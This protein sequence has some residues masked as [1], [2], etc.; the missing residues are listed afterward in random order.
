[1][2]PLILHD[3][4]ARAAGA[5][6]DALE[7][8]QTII[9]PTDTIYGMGGNPWDDGVVGRIRVLKG[10]SPDQPFTLHLATVEEV[11]RFAEI[12]GSA[13]AAIRHLLPGPYTVILPALPAAPACSVSP[14]GVGIRV[15]R[16]PFFSSV[17]AS[18]ARPL[19]GTSVNE[20]GEEPLRDVDAMIDRFPSVD[21]VILGVVSGTPSD[22][23]DLT[24][25]APRALRGRLPASLWISGD[26]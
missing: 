24:S 2:S 6:H 16:H 10:R 18:L 17:V 12:R 23:I 1:M 3:D 13:L 25:A 7:S 4:D 9:F 20:H 19:F 5:L 11:S 21:L 26:P 22:I 14:L 15:P 8:G